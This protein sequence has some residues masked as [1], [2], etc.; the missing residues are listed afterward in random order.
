MSTK[1]SRPLPFPAL[2]QSLGPEPLFSSGRLPALE[3]PLG[4]AEED[5]AR[6]L[7]PSGWPPTSQQP[8]LVV[9]FG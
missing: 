2:R 6:S 9:P 7:P 4:P 5:L 8:C 1:F 3:P